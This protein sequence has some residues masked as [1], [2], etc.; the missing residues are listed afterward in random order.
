MIHTKRLFL[1]PYQTNDAE[2]FFEQMQSN[3]DHLSDYFPNMLNAAHSLEI[4]QEYFIQ[5]SKAWQENRGYAFGIFLKEGLQFVGHI[6]VREI[7]WRV[8]KGEVAYFIFKNHTGQK[9]ASEALKGFR[10]WCFEEKKFKR[11]FMKIAPSNI[12]SIATAEKCDFVRERTLKKDYLKRGEEWVDMYLY[13]YANFDLVKT[14]SDNVDFHHL[15]SLLDSYLHK[16]YGAFQNFY[17]QFN[18]VDNIKNVVIAYQNGR[19]IGCGSFKKYNEDTIEIKRMFLIE[20]L[21]GSGIAHAILSQLEAWAIELQYSYS[22]LETAVKQP[23]SIAF[24]KKNGY[25]LIDNYGQYIGVDNSICFKKQL[26]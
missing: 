21:R 26:T 23:E 7:D 16:T 8:P 10:D 25:H 2:C 15:I 22:V 12:A 24:Y 11:L 6:S 5:K 9:Y 20:E 3:N 1:R 18:K 17:T 14:D 19:P 4:A 13:G